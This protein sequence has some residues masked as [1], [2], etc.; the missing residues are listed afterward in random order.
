M[1]RRNGAAIASS[2][3]WGA[4]MIRTLWFVGLLCAGLAATAPSPAGP[5]AA[6]SPLPPA[7]AE[8][9]RAHGIEP[10]LLYAAALS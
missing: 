2:V 10:R 3:G 1:P 9:A 5:A 6:E 4:S 8:P 7:W